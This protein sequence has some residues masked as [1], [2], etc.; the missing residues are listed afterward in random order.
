MPDVGVYVPL[1]TVLVWM[2]TLLNVS[3]VA[4]FASDNFFVTGVPPGSSTETSRSS[5]VGVVSATSSQMA[6]SAIAAYA[7]LRSAVAAALTGI[8][9]VNVPA[10]M[11]CDPNVN[12]ATA[13]SVADV[14]L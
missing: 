4:R 8:V 9:R 1:P 5:V 14:S 10:T 2:T 7:I 6:L 12:T 11:F 3:A 13:K